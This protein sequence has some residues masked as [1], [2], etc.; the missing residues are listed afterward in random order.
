M[1]GFV[2]IL[3]FI[4]EVVSRGKLEMRSDG[5]LVSVYLGRWSQVQT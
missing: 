4:G 2:V 5:Q 1:L 3:F